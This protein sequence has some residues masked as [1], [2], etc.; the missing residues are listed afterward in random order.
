MHLVTYMQRGHYGLCDSSGSSASTR[1]PQASLLS[2]P[3]VQA[4]VRSGP[5]LPQAV[6]LP[7]R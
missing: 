3:V 4:A 2:L 5:G 6:R 7:A 1:A